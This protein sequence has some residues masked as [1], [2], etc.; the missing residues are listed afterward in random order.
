MSTAEEIA[1]VEIGGIRLACR[2]KMVYPGRPVIIF[3]HDSLGCTALWRDFPDRLADRCRCNFFVY[4]RQGYGASE[5]FSIHERDLDYMHR[6]AA[7]LSDLIKYF[8]FKHVW[9]FGHSD[10]GSIALIAAALYPQLLMGIITEGAHIFVEELTLRGI[11][12]A[13]TAYHHTDLPQKL[14]LYHGLRTADLFRLWAETWLAESFRHWNISAI[15]PEIICPVLVIQGAED[16]YGTEAQVQGI[17]Q[18]VRGPAD[19]YLI[20]QSGHSPHKEASD[21]TLTISADFILRYS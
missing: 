14:E 3:L 19:A 4:D 18:S 11:R 6:E 21:S 1:Y 17:V 8:D 9:L 20:P 2:S 5:A 16:A 12:E 10:G 13:V 7:V 15:L